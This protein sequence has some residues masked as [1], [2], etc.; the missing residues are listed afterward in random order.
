MRLAA[1]K[2]DPGYAHYSAISHKKIDVFLDG[3]EQKHV[4]MADEEAGEILRCVTDAEGH[5]QIDPKNPYRVWTE[6]VRGKV[7]IKVSLPD[8]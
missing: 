6:T 1:N 2:D 7:E 5:I 4:E 8:A 3:V